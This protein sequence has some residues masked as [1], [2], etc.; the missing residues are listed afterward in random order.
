MDRVS[1][2]LGDEGG[3]DFEGGLGKDVVVVVGV[4]LGRNEDDLWFVTKFGEEVLDRVEEHAEGLVE[5]HEGA[6]CGFV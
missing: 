1:Q 3:V 5:C 6:V 2:L 4:S